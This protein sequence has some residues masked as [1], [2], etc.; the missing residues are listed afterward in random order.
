L[1]G[2][3]ALVLGGGFVIGILKKVRK[4]LVRSIGAK[5]LEKIVAVVAK[6]L[7]VDVLSL[8]YRQ[9]GILNYW[10]NDVSGESYVLN[11]ILTHHFQGNPAII[12]DVGAN[13][14]NYTEELKQVFPDAKIYAFEPNFNTFQSLEQKLSGSDVR[15]FCLGLS[16]SAAKRRIYTYATDNKSAHASVYREVLSDLHKADEILEIDFE[17]IALDDFC[18]QHS[19]E[20]IDFLKIDTEGHELEVLSG[21]KQMLAQEKIDII[22][23]EFS[24]MNVIS[25]V[26]LRDFYHVLSDYNIYRIDSKRLIPLFDYSSSNEIFQF[27]NFLAIRKSITKKL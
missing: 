10:N 21:A 22:Q 6:G 18:R 15:R 2:F 27:Q 5:T 4:G 23:F 9:R 25:R 8:A 26:F 13:V 19:I 12:F 16:S 17:T 14:G 7:D 24:E 3:D 1:Q 11:S 20:K